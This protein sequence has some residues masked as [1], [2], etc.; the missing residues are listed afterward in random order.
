MGRAR[1][2]AEFIESLKHTTGPS[3]GQP[4]RLHPFQL[5][6]IR[7]I[8]GAED[9]QGRRVVRTAVLSRPRK[10]GKTEFVAA[11]VL[12]HLCGP[13][14]ELNGQLYSVAVEKE[15]AALVF[16][17]AAQMVRQDPELSAIL[18]VIDSRK[19]IVHFAS[20]SVYVALS[21][22]SKTK[23]GLNPSFV[24]YDE[25]AQAPDRLL[26]DVMT[27]SMGARAEPLFIA[28]SVQ[29]DRADHVMGELIDYG[30][31][32]EAGDI[33]DPSFVLS[34]DEAPEGCAVEDPEAWLASNPALCL[35]RNA[36]ELARA[37]A[38][39][40]R[41]VSWEPTF[42]SLYL[43]QRYSDLPRFVGRA[44]WERL[45]TPGLTLEAL[46][47]MPAVVGLDLSSV[48]D[49][50]ALVVVARGPTGTLL[51][52]PFFFLPADGLR[53]KARLDRVPYDQWAK[54]KWLFT[55]PGRS[56]NK[57]PVLQLLQHI[58]TVVRVQATAYDRWRIDDLKA[59]IK[60]VG[61]NEEALK[62]EPFGQGFRDMAPAVDEF[63][64]LVLSGGLAHNGSPVLNW[65]VSNA[66]VEKDPA[67]NRKLTKS[68][69]RGRIDGLVAAVQAV[70]WWKRAPA[71]VRPRITPLLASRSESEKD[72]ATQ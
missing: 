64:S 6:D 35:F 40:K 44:D 52:L 48:S 39:A 66:V 25:L 46:R 41:M 23:H 54:A 62:L 34:I 24:V 2:V 18:K 38:R 51:I 63:E 5:E 56:V 50:C 29:G 22:E 27:T 68:K 72:R 71:P 13:E 26:Y 28:I 9:E 15:Q 55:T 19:R 21:R 37:A 30:R 3:A 11:L 16:N 53:D 1:A 31:A 70:G 57:R 69:A 33:N 65:N 60:E 59:Y 12:V 47:G 20:G 4:F 61:A 58:T 32:V 42:R 14:A 7:R 8:Y 17:A 45:Y 67:G 10:N 49:L 36:D 43:N